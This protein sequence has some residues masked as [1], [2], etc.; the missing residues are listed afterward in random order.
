MLDVLGLFKTKLFMYK[1]IIHLEHSN[2]NISYKNNKIKPS[3]I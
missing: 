3:Y 2:P 1:E